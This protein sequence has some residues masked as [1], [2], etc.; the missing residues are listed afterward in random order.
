M[1]F[2]LRYGRKVQTRKFESLEIV[3]EHEF[4]SSN[5]GC[6][7][8]KELLAKIVDRWIEE[9]RSRLQKEQ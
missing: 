1:K 8:A 6:D 4:D 2:T 7:K 5:M 9:E 3:L